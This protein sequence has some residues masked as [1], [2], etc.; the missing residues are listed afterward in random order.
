[1]LTC[2]KTYRDVPFAHRQPRHGGHC[3]LIHGHNW[4]FTVTFACEKLDANGFVVDFGELKYLKRWL[5]ENLDHACVFAESDPEKDKLLAAFPYLFKPYILPCAS[6]EG[7]AAHV[8]GVFDE[9]V[10][11]HTGGRAWVVE[12][13][14]DEDSRNFVTYRKN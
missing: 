13:R 11:R 8:F 9:M 7:L 6:A 3:A 5:D 12:L 4:D 10:R 14:L 2:S 1:M